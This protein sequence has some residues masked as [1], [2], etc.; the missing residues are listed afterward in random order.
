MCIR[1]R[2]KTVCDSYLFM[3]KKVPALFGRLYKQTNKQN[4]FSD[5]VPK[6]SGMFS[7]LLPV[8]YTHLDVYKRQPMPSTSTVEPYTEVTRPRE[9]QLPCFCASR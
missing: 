2:D 7:N 4:L 5:L 6:L 1:D 3:A 8:S 9:F